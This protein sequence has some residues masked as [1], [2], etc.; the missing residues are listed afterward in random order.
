MNLNYI[1]YLANYS[2]GILYILAV[3][4]VVALAVMLDRFWSLRSTILRGQSLIRDTA[5]KA[6]LAPADLTVLRN[7]AGALPEAV[8]LDTALRHAAY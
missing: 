8:L 7:A 3:L 2:D 4:L 1:I 6:T 5:G